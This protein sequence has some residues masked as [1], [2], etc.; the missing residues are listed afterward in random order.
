M[1]VRIYIKIYG[2]VVGVGFRYATCKK[3]DELNILGYVKNCNDA[4]LEI[5][6][7]GEEEKL[8]DLLGWTR[9]GPKYARVDKVDYKWLDNQNEFKGFGIRY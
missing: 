9:K 4:S 5:G 7:E 2:Q 8:N 6:A 1:K 3:A